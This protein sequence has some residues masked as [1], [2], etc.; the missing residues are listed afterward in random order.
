MSAK[1]GTANAVTSAQLL[2]EMSPWASVLQ[3]APVVAEP[4][5]GISSYREW[6]LRAGLQYYPTAVLDTDV[7]LLPFWRE[8]VQNGMRP[9]ELF[10]G[11]AGDVCS[12]KLAEMS[13][14]EGVICGPPCQPFAG[15]GLQGGSMDVRTDVFEAC[16]N[17]IIE[18][19]GRGT[20]VFFVI[21]NS[22]KL[23]EATHRAYLTEQLLKLETCLPYFQVDR[24]E[25]EA[26]PFLPIKRERLFIR[27]LRRDCLPEAW[28]P[29]P[30]PLALSD[31]P[32][33][34]VSLESILDTCLPSTSPASLSN[35]QAGNLRVYKEEI[36]KH[37]QAEKA[38]G[39]ELP[40]LTACMEVDRNPLKTFGPKW[41]LGKATSMRTS[42][43]PL[44]LVSVEDM[45][46]P[47][48][49]MRLHRLMKI[50][51]RYEIL[52][53]RRSHAA[54]FD[55]EGHAQHAI[56]NALS[57][58]QLAAAASPLLRAAVESGVLQPGL[59]C[60]RVD[61]MGLPHS[62]TKET[63]AA[64]D[65][66]TQPA[67]PE[68]LPSKKASAKAKAKEKQKPKDPKRKARAAA[69]QQQPAGRAE[70]DELEAELERI[71]DETFPDTLLD[72]ET[73]PEEGRALSPCRH[74]AARD[75][76]QQ[77]TQSPTSRNS[78]VSEPLQTADSRCRT[79]AHPDNFE[80]RIFA[81]P[82]V[83]SSGS[84][85]SATAQRN[86][87]RLCFGQGNQQ[88]VGISISD[89]PVPELLQTADSRCR[90]AAHLAQPVPFFPSQVQPRMLDTCTSSQATQ[91]SGQDS[92][93]GNNK[94][95]RRLSFEGLRNILP[96]ETIDVDHES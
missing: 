18:Q 1:V 89:S 27:G 40:S 12:F 78:R 57:P 29:L 32:V 75:A 19:G 61:I 79:A 59:P 80:D 68:K 94:K 38:A 31:L 90:T 45:E 15:S 44:F 71:I 66:E 28:G 88:D 7:S 69:K 51:E 25:L 65:A 48:Q 8:Q 43:P 87:A 82:S 84:E 49:E 4:C 74:P 91:A 37:V 63:E 85:S 41:A 53:Q 39:R 33:S 73:Q 2:Y 23:S 56:G 77:P 95:Q 3:R 96:T 93:R 9:D 11:T 81:T 35:S 20:L 16:L 5:V 17:M 13:S 22:P 50:G 70:P 62:R 86:K 6:M 34:G 47:W 67:Q 76:E 36:K 24:V 55:T 92:S 83:H 64:P 52:G 54:V 21:E 42:G 26:A 10:L 72:C 30:P 58:L 60:P 46:K 14:A